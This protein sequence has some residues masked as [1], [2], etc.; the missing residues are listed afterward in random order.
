[1][2]KILVIIL[3]LTSC[4]FQNSGNYWD[5]NLN[6]EILDL[7]TTAGINTNLNIRSVSNNLIANNW[8]DLLDGSIPQTLYSL[9]VFAD[10]GAR[11]MSFSDINGA[12]KN[13]CNGG[14]DNSSSYT[15]TFGAAGNNDSRWRGNFS[16]SHEYRN[17]AKNA[18][19]KIID[20]QLVQPFTHS[21][22]PH[23]HT[24]QYFL[25]CDNDRTIKKI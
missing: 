10:A 7:P 24:K 14:T 22:S 9:G 1:M 16:F 25:V 18:N 12:I 21:D 11:W 20:Y 19:F 13:S 5:N 3:F 4:S 2:K 23:Y 15:G 6:N 8:S 17:Y